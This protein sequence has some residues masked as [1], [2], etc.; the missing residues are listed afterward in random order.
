MGLQL[1]IIFI[2]LIDLFVNNISENWASGGL[3]VKKL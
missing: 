2:F 1:L 3:A